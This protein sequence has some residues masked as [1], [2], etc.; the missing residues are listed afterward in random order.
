MANLTV[1]W[2]IFVHFWTTFGPIFGQTGLEAALKKRPPLNS[3]RSIDPLEKIQ[4]AASNTDDTVYAF[5]N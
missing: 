1:K 3:S 5:L 4:A 2:A